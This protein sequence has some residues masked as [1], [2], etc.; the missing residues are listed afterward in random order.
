MRSGWVTIGLMIK[1]LEKTLSNGSA[2][3]MRALEQRNDNTLPLHTC[4]TDEEL[5]YVIAAYKNVLRE[6]IK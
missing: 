6:Y 3:K 4:F 1:Q 2:R 5:E